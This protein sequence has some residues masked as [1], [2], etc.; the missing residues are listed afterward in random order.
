M[1]ALVALLAFTLMPSAFAQDTEPVTRG[2][3]GFVFVGGQ[4]VASV[5]LTAGTGYTSV[6]S[7]AFTAGGAG[8]VQAT[9][10]ATLKVVSSVTITAGGTGYTV[11]DVLTLSGGTNTTVATFT[12][13]TVSSGVITAAA[14]TTAG[15]YSVPVTTTGAAVTGGTGTGA[16]VTVGW[17]V[18]ALT[19]TNVGPIYTSAPTVTFS[20]GAGANAA[21]TAVLAALP[22]HTV[23]FCQI[24]P[25]TDTVVDTVTFFTRVRS[26]GTYSGDVGLAGKTLKAGVPYNVFGKTIKLASGTAI[27]LKR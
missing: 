7:V 8:S 25:I 11:G 27:V 12:V 17:G 19:I 5:T 18:G 10:V 16:T 20:G 22:T 1:L 4:T 26:T 14:L 3:S 24:L 9:A 23:D 13:S 2:D 15:V 6:P 21:G